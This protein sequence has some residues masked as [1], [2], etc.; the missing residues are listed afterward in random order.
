MKKLLVLFVLMATASGIYAQQDTATI[1]FGKNKILIISDKQDTSIHKIMVNDTVEKNIHP[2]QSNRF[3]G[4][5]AGIDI[6]L[7]GYITSDYSFSLPTSQSYL[8]LNQAKSIN[9]NL[10][11]LEWNISI[12][13][14]Y[15]GIVSG[16]GVSF[17]NY[18]F[19]KNIHLISD[20]TALTYT[21]DT[22]YKYRKNK[23]AIDY[24]KLPLLIEFHI[25]VNHH[26]DRV[27]INAG[28]VGALRIGSHIKQVYE[29]NG[30]KKTNKEFRNYFLSPLAYSAQLRVGYN[31]IG[32]FGECQ[33]S[34]LFKKDKGPSLYPWT[35][36]LS[37]YF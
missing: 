28:V 17:N 3:K 30:D 21:M 10:N 26:R 16:L 20:S 37:L 24:L 7:N 6:G 5:W 23:L 29:I 35:A 13:K 12:Y 34:S 2:H 15:I 27:F 14:K 31:N 9:I 11:F 8:E 22:L 4:R 32:V 18:F 1:S 36:G 33:L 25:P 19:D